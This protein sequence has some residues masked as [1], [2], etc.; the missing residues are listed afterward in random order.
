MCCAH[1]HPCLS[2][3]SIPRGGRMLPDFLATAQE[4]KQRKPLANYVLHPII[5]D[6]ESFFRSQIQTL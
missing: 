5:F 3:S 6:I 1:W 2:S 4:S